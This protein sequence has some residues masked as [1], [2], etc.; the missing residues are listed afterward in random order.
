MHD[1]RV[2]GGRSAFRGAAFLT[3]VTALTWVVGCSDSPEPAVGVGGSGGAAPAATTSTGGTGGAGG[4]GGDTTT[5]GSG[6]AGGDAGVGTLD[7]ASIGAIEA[8]YF[9]V[10]QGYVQ[11]TLSDYPYLCD[12]LE[13]GVQERPTRDDD[14]GRVHFIGLLACDDEAQL[15]GEALDVVSGTPD[16]LVVG[17]AL[18]DMQAFDPANDSLLASGKGAGGTLTLAVDGADLQVTVSSTSADG[19][20][21]FTTVAQACNLND[22]LLSVATGCP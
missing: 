6:G 16:T 12:E 4:T 15:A 5:G 14:A 10:T 2:E 7:G 17:D 13:E 11:V 22:G 9:E 21:S 1:T 3:V 18:V 20:L 19:P 8:A